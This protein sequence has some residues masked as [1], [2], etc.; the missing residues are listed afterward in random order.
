MSGEQAGGSEIA[1]SDPE[2]TDP[3]SGDT[4]AIL[5]EL[6]D[7]IEERKETLPEDS[8]TASLFT[9]E[10]GENAVLEKLGEETT[11]LLLAA[12]DDDHEEIAHESAD[13]VY[14]L[15]VLLSMKDMDLAEL[16]AELRERR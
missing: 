7:V 1:E 2:D 8:Y 9:H 12:K 4:A 15:L 5:D 13:I 6:F 14:H 3:E 11:E 16:R 10:R